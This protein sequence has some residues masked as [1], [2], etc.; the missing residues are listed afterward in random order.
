MH[1]GPKGP[2]K[3]TGPTRRRPGASVCS[4]GSMEFRILGPTEVLD[5]G[6]Q[7]PLPRGRGRAL[8]ALLLLHPGEPV[9]ADRLIDELWGESP[10]AT[11]R[12]VV[13]GL[14]SSLRSVL[15]P[16]RGQ[17]P[18]GAPLQTVGSGYQFAIEP[19]AVD[20]HRFK[21]LIDETRGV[22][23]EVRAV[24]LSAALALWRGAAPGG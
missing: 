13:H 17:A 16:G 10:P 24:K 3:D 19:D 2:L 8:L 14:V 12:T 1:P 9:S 15:E 4:G 11:A 6:R 21:R 22:P 5:G 18:P 20:A 7:V 23:A